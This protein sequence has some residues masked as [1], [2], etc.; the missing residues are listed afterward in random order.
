MNKYGEKPLKSA[1]GAA[2]RPRVREDLLRPIL[3]ISAIVLWPL[4]AVGQSSPSGVN[5]CTLLRDPTQLRD[6][7]YRQEG[8]RLPP[9][10]AGSSVSSGADIESGVMPMGRKARPARIEERDGK[11]IAAGKSLRGTIDHS[12]RG[13]P[14]RSKPPQRPGAIP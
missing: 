11:R 3:V 13:Q 2:R 4:G 14:R 5:D 9:G 12:A 6:C 1:M 10:Q 8:R 7:L